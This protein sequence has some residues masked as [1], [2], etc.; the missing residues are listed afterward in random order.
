MTKK[1]MKKKKEEKKRKKFSYVKFV[2]L[3]IIFSLKAFDKYETQMI[4]P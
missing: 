4:D 3:F 1:K 2:C